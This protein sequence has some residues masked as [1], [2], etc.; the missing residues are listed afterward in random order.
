ML[1]LIIRV[2]FYTLAGAIGWTSA[3]TMTGPDNACI[4]IPAFAD[5]ISGGAGVV[6]GGALAVL[7]FISSRI[8]KRRGGVT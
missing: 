2:L 6:T 1:A 3:I 5:A 8:A 4:N 7:T